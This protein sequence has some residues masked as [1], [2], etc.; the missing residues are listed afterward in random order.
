MQKDGCCHDHP[1]DIFHGEQP[2]VIVEGL[3]AGSHLFRLIAAAA[4]DVGDGNQLRIGKL[5]HL[6]EQILSASAD[7]NHAEAHTIIGSQH[8]GGRIRQKRCCSHGSLFHKPTTGVLPH[9]TLLRLQDVTRE[10]HCYRF[11]LGPRF[12][13]HRVTALANSE[14]CG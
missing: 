4:V 7:P 8:A 6:L 12:G 2:P 11:V 9:V 10:R 1:V 13:R 3:N 5:Q 14:P